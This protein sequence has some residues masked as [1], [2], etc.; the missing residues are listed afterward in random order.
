LA[1]AM[2]MTLLPEQPLV[3]SVTLADRNTRAS[4]ALC[5]PVT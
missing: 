3:Q 5:R 2:I 4:T 1:A